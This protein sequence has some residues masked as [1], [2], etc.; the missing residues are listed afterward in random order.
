MI[1]SSGFYFYFYF[2]TWQVT[3]I[4]LILLE[5]YFLSQKQ[6][7]KSFSIYF[8][9]FMSFELK[10]RRLILIQFLEGVWR[11]LYFILF[12]MTS[13]FI[14]NKTAISINYSID[15]TRYLIIKE[16]YLKS[17]R[18]CFLTD[19]VWLSFF[20]ESGLVWLDANNHFHARPLES[21]VTLLFTKKDVLSN[22]KNSQKF[23]VTGQVNKS[24]KGKNCSYYSNILSR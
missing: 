13:I 23:I 6:W 20:L 24:K 4:S 18:K 8:L 15:L 21:Y 5:F 2:S 7:L 16:A 22:P 14:F 10:E 12:Y 11:N 1:T 17:C 3:T 9:M 19:L